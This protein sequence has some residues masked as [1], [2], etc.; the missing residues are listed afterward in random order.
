[1]RQHAVSLDV[2]LPLRLPLP[3]PR[4][5]SSGVAV[6]N[7]RTHAGGVVLLGPRRV[8]TARLMLSQAL[9]RVR[10]PRQNRST[11]RHRRPW[12]G[13]P[14]SNQLRLA[15]A[16]VAPD[17]QPLPTAPRSPSTGCAASSRSESRRSRKFGRPKLSNWTIWGTA[18]RR[19][20]A[21]PHHVVGSPI[22]ALHQH[23]VPMC[24][25]RTPSRARIDTASRLP[26]DE[27]KERADAEGRLLPSRDDAE[28]G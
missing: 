8:A 3:Y 13:R 9:Q 25:I 20:R 6:D 2:G 14:L 22:A 28:A 24:A 18:S 17:R 21:S 4:Q 1:M 19:S 26:L 16:A 5:S 27:T 12:D 15:R 10:L 11:G 23:R 7:L